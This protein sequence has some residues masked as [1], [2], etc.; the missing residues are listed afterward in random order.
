LDAILAEVQALTGVDTRR[1]T[2]LGFS[3]GAQFAHRYLM[4]HPRRVERAALGAPG[5]Y[6]FP[7]HRKPYPYGLGPSDES[8]G[9]DFEPDRFLHV[10]IA[11]FVGADDT[12]EANLRLNPDVNH[13]QGLTRVERA[14]RWT[15]AMRH[16]A[17]ARGLKPRVHCTVVPGIGH[18]FADF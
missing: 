6:L 17:E 5:W 10:P 15:M 2:L 9:V 3:G 7:D 18:S 11:V 14:K 8:P 12:G 16:A 13:Q 1:C 4:A